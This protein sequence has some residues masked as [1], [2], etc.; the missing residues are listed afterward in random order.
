M[1][2]NYPH[3]IYDCSEDLKFSFSPDQVLQ[4]GKYEP[5]FVASNISHFKLICNEK[6][7]LFEILFSTYGDFVLSNFFLL[8]TNMGGSK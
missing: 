6:Y 3:L 7:F 5:S 2:S 1:R 8:S 4:G